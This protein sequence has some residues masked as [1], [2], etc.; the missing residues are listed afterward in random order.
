MTRQPK[1]CWLLPL[2]LTIV[3]G[4]LQGAAVV[5]AQASTD[6]PV[7]E[8]NDSLRSRWGDS[9]R[10]EQGRFLWL[11]DSLDTPRW[12]EQDAA[13]DRRPVD[14]DDFMWTRI[15][16]SEGDWS[17][18]VLFLPQVLVAFE[19]YLD[20]TLIY[21]R[22]DFEASRD[23]KFTSM[24]SH[25]IPLP[26]QDGSSVISCRIYSP[27]RDFI[28]IRTEQHEVLVGQQV[29]VF[30]RLF[31]SNVG[32]LIL[33]SL[34]FVAGLISLAIFLRRLRQRIWYLLSFAWLTCIL[35]R[36]KKTLA[37][38]SSVS[39]KRVRPASSLGF[40]E[41]TITRGPGSIINDS[42]PFSG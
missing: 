31:F 32:S 13:K 15:E 41:E 12:L 26:E 6:S 22:G 37:G 34:F 40:C 7:L 19:V 25:L 29:D 23:H 11:T 28:G 30:R 18:P 2:T 39:R 16:I 21:R 3:F 9:P 24:V 42:K 20:T 10:D 36:R 33:G 8:V 4:V 27:Y 5:G 35:K 17:Q 38:I 1:L 14:H